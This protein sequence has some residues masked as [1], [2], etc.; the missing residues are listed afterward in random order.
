M[1]PRRKGEGTGNSMVYGN[2]FVPSHNV[3]SGH[4]PCHRPRSSS[5]HAPKYHPAPLA[6]PS[7]GCGNVNWT[8]HQAQAARK[9]ATQVQMFCF[10]VVN[11]SNP[12][13]LRM[14]LQAPTRFRSSMPKE[15]SFPVIWDSGASL[16]VAPHRSDFVGTYS[17]PPITLK[18]KGLAK[19]LNI[20]GQGHVM[21]AMHD[22]NGMLRGIKVPAYHVPGCNVRLLSTSSLLQTY[23]NEHIYLD[24]NKMRLSGDGVSDTPR[25]PVIAMV[26][27]TNNLPTSQAYTCSDTNIPVEALN[28]TITTVCAENH[29]LTEPEKELLHWHY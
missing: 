5:R 10:E 15:S 19:G 25:A 27:P 21:W 9:I 26:D 6:S 16:S 13:T 12:A 24:E 3:N 17:K 1:R 20:Q 18:L 28:T 14:A 23:K 22:T 11:P 8:R 2:D 7:H 4:Q 29:N